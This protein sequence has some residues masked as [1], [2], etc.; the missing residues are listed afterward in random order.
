RHGL[1][2]TVGIAIEARRLDRIPAERPRTLAEPR[3]ERRGGSGQHLHGG[4]RL[5]GS[6][7]RR[8]FVRRE[9]LDAITSAPFIE[10]I[11]R[12]TVIE[13]AVD[14]ASAANAAAFDISD[15]RF[16]E[17]GGDAGIAVLLEDF[18]AR[19]MGRGID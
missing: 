8:K 2:A 5:A 11:R 10:H 9:L 7:V 3:R 18:L 14:L 12:R 19:E 1:L 17:G 16:A 13:A 6:E 4:H 15:G